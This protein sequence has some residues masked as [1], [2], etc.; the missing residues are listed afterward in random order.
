MKSTRRGVTVCVLAAV[1]C[2]LGYL[3]LSY[4]A[5]PYRVSFMYETL[6]MTPADARDGTSVTFT[7]SVRNDG[8]RLANVQIRVVEPCNSRGEGTVLRDLTGQVINP[9]VN[10]YR[11]SGTFRAPSG[12]KTGVVVELLDRSGTTLPAPVIAGS[13]YRRL[14]PACY[15]LAKYVP[16]I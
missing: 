16:L 3:A 1:V 7:F 6:T 8:P 9:G 15:K 10:S 14:E 4:A 5:G 12:D 2:F 13:G 11:V